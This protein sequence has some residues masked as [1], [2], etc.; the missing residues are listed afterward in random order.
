MGTGMPPRELP[1]P[2]ARPNLDR[3]D[4]SRESGPAGGRVL[5]APPGPIK[6]STCQ[7]SE[8]NCLTKDSSGIRETPI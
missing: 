3:C 1:F 2:R 6:G 7:K 5:T 4:R 8:I